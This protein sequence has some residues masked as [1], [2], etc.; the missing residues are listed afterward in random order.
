[1][2]FGFLRKK[3]RPADRDRSP[4]RRAIPNPRTFDVSLVTPAGPPI[5]AE[6]VNLSMTG[7]SIRV[8]LEDDPALTPGDVAE[9]K[10]RNAKEDWL[11]TTPAR[12]CH[13]EQS[14]YR[15]LLYGFE[16]INLGNLYSQMDDAFAK[17]FNRRAKRRMQPNLDEQTP[18]QMKCEEYALPGLMYDI[19]STGIGVLVPRQQGAALVRDA[20]VSLRFRLPKARKEIVGQGWVRRLDSVAGRIVAGIEFDMDSNGGFSE[21]QALINEFIEHRRQEMFDRQHAWGK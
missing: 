21:S 11:V 10:L 15:H 20:R 12:A 1:M 13:V 4:Y 8:L 16:F 5:D 6:L 9:V 17:F 3:A 7:C 18:I 19:S 2:K 14:G